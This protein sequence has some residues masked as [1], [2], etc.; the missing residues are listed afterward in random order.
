MNKTKNILIIILLLAVVGLWFFMSGKNKDKIKDY[1]NKI[2]S[3]NI[4]NEDLEI[5][6]EIQKKKVDSVN[7]K[8]EEYEKIAD[9][10]Q[11]VL[12]N[13]H[14]CE[15]RVDLQGKEI[16][17]LRGALNQCK[18]AK[19]IYV[20]TIG[21]CEEIIVNKDE[22]ILTQIQIR[23]I[24]KKERKRIFLKGAGVGAGVVGAIV[25]IGALLSN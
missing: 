22:I 10:L 1:E 6:K 2:D 15:E 24:E 11:K 8:Q 18:E 25:L 3:I 19:V 17:S 13:P 23:K 20:K 21:I 7:L 12:L 14:S 5:K 9:S 4:I 16:T